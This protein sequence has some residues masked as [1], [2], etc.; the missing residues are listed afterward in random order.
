LS[1][2]EACYEPPFETI[3]PHLFER[4]AGLTTVVAVLQDWDPVR[5]AF[6]RRVRASGVAV[7]VVI[8]HD[9][10]TSVEW[11]RAG[12]ELGD[13]EA[14]SSADIERATALR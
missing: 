10:P 4:L 7:R 11:Q 14:F 5:E 12:D 1:C 13:V 8:V 2:V 9:G 6:L 3:G